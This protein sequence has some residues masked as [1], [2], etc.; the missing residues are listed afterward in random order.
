ML[1]VMFTGFM[2]EGSWEKGKTKGFFSMK[3][4]HKTQGGEMH[5]FSPKKDDH[6]EMFDMNIFFMSLSSCMAVVNIYY[7]GHKRNQR[8]VRKTAEA[9]MVC[10]PQPCS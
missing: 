4:L 7:Q 9:L 3:F 2:S 1:L 10:S 8:K 6:D 5:F